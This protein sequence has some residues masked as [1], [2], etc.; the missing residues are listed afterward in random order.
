MIQ[1]PVKNFNGEYI[2]NATFTRFN[3]LNVGRIYKVED[4]LEEINAYK[5]FLIKKRLKKLN[6]FR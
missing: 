4:Y 3:R 2:V 6:N 5:Q 1:K